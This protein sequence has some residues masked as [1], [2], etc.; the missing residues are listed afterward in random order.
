MA[1]LVQ[2]VPQLE[3]RGCPLERSLCDFSSKEHPYDTDIR[4]PLL[5]RGP[6]IKAGSIFNFPSGNVDLTPTLL[7]LAGGAAYG[8]PTA[9]KPSAACD[10]GESVSDSRLLSLWLCWVN[11]LAV[12]EF[13]DGKSMTAFLTPTLEPNADLT[14]WRKAFLNEYMSVGTYYNDHSNCWGNDKQCPGKMPRGP[15]GNEIAVM[16][17]GLAW[18]EGPDYTIFVNNT[19][20]A[21]APPGL[22]CVESNITGGGNC[23]FVDSTHSNNWRQLRVVGGSDGLDFNCTYSIPSNRTY[24]S[25]RVI[26]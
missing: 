8:E 26:P 4:V 10:C 20:E 7:T 11:C 25:P 15:I 22:K 1:F 14:T 13:M 6:G 16:P 23:Y 12:P 3:L 5:A 21:E 9:L 17:I 24:L 18:I 19:E 2:F